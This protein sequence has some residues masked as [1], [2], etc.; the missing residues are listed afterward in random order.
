MTASSTPSGGE[1]GP[2]LHRPVMV[3]EVLRLLELQPGM[4]VVDGTVGG[5]GHS[6]HILNHIGPEGVLIGLDRDPT[7]TQRAAAVLAAKN[8][9]LY[10]AKY[11]ELRAILDELHV[12]FV[13]RLFLDLGM[14]SDQLADEQ[15]GFSFES[16]GPL[17]L[18]FNPHEGRPAF[19]LL[20]SAALEELERIFREFGEDPFSRQ[21]AREIIR[22][23]GGQPLRTAR[24]LV[25]IV[26]QAVPRDA[27]KTSRRH[28]ATRVFQ[29]LRIAVNDELRILE[30][31]LHHTV[32]ETLQAGGRSVV[33][34]FHS[35]EDRLAKIAFRDTSQW[36]NL[37][38]KPVTAT[39][40][41]QKVNPR[42]R[43]A[44]LRAAV[45]KQPPTRRQP[46]QQAE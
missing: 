2:T 42:S 1:P 7:M 35:L 34:T 25:E 28:P 13:D 21:I 14:S 44:K 15:R 17:D 27:R 24:D 30:Y 8:C 40:N 9:R 5:G 46:Q 12:D 22:R 6:Q 4:T 38:P 29:A 37:T 32:H 26:Q 11:S 23:R 45:K 31:T 18:R 33:L 41:E 39:A 43:T 10:T 36:H 3:R 20:E 16:P 19:E